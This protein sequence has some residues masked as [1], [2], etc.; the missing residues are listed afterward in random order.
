MEYYDVQVIPSRNSVACWC[1]V[2]TLVAQHYPR[3]R[4][5]TNVDTARLK[6]DLKL[7]EGKWLLSTDDFFNMMLDEDIIVFWQRLD[8]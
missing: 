3:A 7:A 4:I 2:L 8:S 1:A 6:L 5:S